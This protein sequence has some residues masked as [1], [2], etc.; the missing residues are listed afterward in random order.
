MDKTL[1]VNHVA[2]F[3]SSFKIELKCSNQKNFLVS[4]K[5]MFALLSTLDAMQMEFD[6]YA[7]RKVLN[8][9]LM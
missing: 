1:K 9:S 4:S 3:S 2:T 5:P 8:L 7:L 6:F